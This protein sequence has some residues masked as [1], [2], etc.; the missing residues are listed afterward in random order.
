VLVNTGIVD[1]LEAEDS[2]AFRNLRPDL[3]LSVDRELLRAAGET[4]LDAA[5][6]ALVRA[7]HRV[8][9]TAGRQDTIAQPLEEGVRAFP[10]PTKPPPRPKRK[11]WTGWGKLLAGAGLAGL[12]VA[13]GVAM[14]TVV[15]PL[16]P[17]AVGVT[18]PSVLGS[19]AAGVSAVVEA[20]GAFRGE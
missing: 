17:L 4:D 2:L 7:A 9:E 14:G 19:C 3:L 16:A 1:A 20:V 18:W 6:A 12:D 13:G 10:S 15:G 5:I 8:G 11:W